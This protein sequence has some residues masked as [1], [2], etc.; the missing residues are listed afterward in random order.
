MAQR[1]IQRWTALAGC[2]ARSAVAICALV[3]D[4]TLLADDPVAAL[5]PADVEYFE[6]HIR[7][8][9]VQHCYECHS[10]KEPKGSLRLDYRGG[11]QQG[12]DSG[13]ALVPGDP[14]QS[15]LVERLR[16]DDADLA[17]P[18]GKPRLP[19]D[20]IAA[21]EEWI[22]RGAPDPRDEPP[23]AEEAARATWEALLAERRQW[24]SL[25]PV[26]SPAVPQ[27]A[28]NSWPRDPIDQFLLA[29]LEEAGLAPAPAAD[30]QTLLRR[31][32]FV[33]TGLP[34]TPVEL[35]EF[36][37][38][39]DSRAYERLVDRLLASPH[40]GER[41][42][43]HWMDVVRYGDTYGYE[44]DV[45][46]KGAW[47]YRDYL[48][49][50]FNADVPFD[51]LV[52]EQIAGDLLVA[53]RIDPVQ[54]IDESRIG[55]MFFQMGEK[56]HGD[57]ADFDGVHQEMLNN[58]IDAFSKAFLGLTVACARCHDH[59]LDAVSQRDYYALGGVLISSR[60]VS[61]TLDRPERNRDTIASLAALK[62]P[63]R[64]EVGAWWQAEA[65]TIPRYLLA[66]Q[67]ALDQRS[68]AATLADGLDPAHLE[69]WNTA[70]ASPADMEP[71]LEQ[72][73][74]PWVLVARAVGGGS[75]VA[76]AWQQMAG[77][78]AALRQERASHNAAHFQTLVDFREG[79]PP[80]WSIDGVGLRGGPVACG[81][82]TVALAGDAAIGRLLPGGLFT[83]VLSP[84]LNGAVRTPYLNTLPTAHVSFEVCGGD[85]AA[86]RTVVDNAF[87][88][89]R[90]T[91]LTQA[92][93]AWVL[94]AHVPAW[95]TRHVYLELATKTSNPN[96]PP[97][98][99]LGVELSA[100][101]MADPR[102]WF[103][104][105]RVVIHQ[106]PSTPLDELGR[107]EPLLAGDA[108]TNLPAAAERVAQWLRDAVHRWH[109]SA[110]GED[111][112]R[113]LN[114]LLERGLLPNRSESNAPAE[115]RD[116]VRAYREQERRLLEPQSV[117]GLA[118]V[119]LGFD[120]PLNVRGAYDNLADAVPR[121]GVEV[122]TGVGGF[123]ATG[124]GRS[125]LAELV[126]SPQNPLTARVFVNRVWQWVFGT[127]LVATSD[128]FGHLGELPSHP[129]LLD[130]L[131][132]TFV[133]DGWSVKRLVRRLV[134]TAAFQQSGATTP[135]ALEVDPRNR[136]LHHYPL[137]RLE[138]EAIRDSLL[139]VS[140]R[141]DATLYGP[142]IDPPRSNEDPLK[143]LFNGPLDGLGRRSIYTKMTIMEPP[144]FLATFNQPSPKIPTGRRDVTNVPAQA[145]ALLN[146]PLVADQA[147]FWAARLVAADH[148]TPRDRLTAMFRSALGRDPQSEELDRWAALVDDLAVLHGAGSD[149]LRSHQVWQDVAH[150]MYNVKEFI[151]VR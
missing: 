115:V 150:T 116:L 18:Q 75:D 79:T 48:I 32:A 84:R 8:A 54:Q 64:E 109:G 132:A 70:L 86:Y 40:F 41:L 6:T 108:P 12:G 34:P 139:A 87:L 124:S 138:A 46:A 39:G 71:A 50:A 131:A 42:A 57:S 141:L 144:K 44:W 52:R 136:L 29:R 31:L 148:A 122:L 140:G 1:A 98:W 113:L 134:T 120:Y 90:Q 77:R 58:K 101:Q 22:R 123:H 107:F 56:R 59:K 110:A 126:A 117:N 82:F 49:R 16:T 51:Q 119:D 69:A 5:A 43:R 45:P 25:Q 95:Q 67:A 89:E 11:W 83:G 121:G 73:L 15:L 99:G 33:L 35:D 30:R 3:T 53:P 78:Y 63:I 114:G 68:D 143:R 102:S 14:Q 37:S 100:E 106:A 65:E 142:P 61:N 80:G 13:A 66:A 128:D 137:R 28:D 85:F 55:P 47:R 20:V 111:D 97:R 151:Y 135:H 96:F 17:M 129:E 127:G 133:V 91:Y 2:L 4:Q 72:L 118:D 38:D 62:T 19:D 147:A 146:D 125:E 36:L 23:T 130:H 27:V 93:P 88:T 145:L 24:W 60:W 105:T 112:V 76:T 81:D 26:Q 10:G 92:D 94:F 103:G 149:V 21:F 9:L 74:T 104:V 7:P